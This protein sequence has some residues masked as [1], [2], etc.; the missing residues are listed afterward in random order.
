MKQ[1]A[2]YFLFLLFLNI[3]FYSQNV[4][5]S[6]ELPSIKKNVPLQILNCNK[7]YFYVLRYNK[8]SHDFILERRAK[9]T[10]EMLSFKALRLDTIN[11]KYFD[12]ENLDYLI[13]EIDHKFYFLFVREYNKSKELF[14]NEIDTLGKSSGY[15]KIGQIEQEGKII[16]FSIEF[17]ITDSNNLLIIAA[18]MYENNSTKKIALLFNPKTHNPIWIKKLPFENTYTGYSASFT[19]NN[20]NDL[21]FFQ[22]KSHLNGYKRIFQ[23]N[24]Q[25]SAPYFFYDS[26]ILVGILADQKIPIKHVLPIS[27][28][29]ALHSATIAVFDKKISC[30][31]HFSINNSKNESVQS[32]YTENISSDFSKIFNS[33]THVFPKNIINQL[34]FYDGTDFDQAGYKDYY[35]HF[36][37]KHGNNIF[38]Q[39]ER[40]E[41]NYVKEIIYANINEQTNELA[42]TKVI[43]RKMSYFEHRTRFSK[44][45]NSMVF[46]SDSSII[47]IHLENKKNI[48]VLCSTFQFSKFE[49]QNELWNS[50]LVAYIQSYSG[51]EKKKL[52]YTNAQYDAVPMKYSGTQADFVFYL[53]N[54][55]KEKFGF[56]DSIFLKK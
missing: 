31:T 26:L 50:N 28:L 43:P 7:N 42:D 16:D 13:T 15:I 9:R 37:Q 22:I 30:F 35:I 10:A 2:T 52:I 24:R 29:T 39:A 12:L 11:S 18:I 6:R 8:I 41:V 4:V 54:G 40:K 33:K 46:L 19:C 55:D 27:N 36:F 5:L 56:V 25:T 51:T 49:K 34:T 47:N 21:Y 20:N 48:D 17:K 1:A 14:L 3:N 44:I 32:F 23:D 38:Y 53:V 45:G